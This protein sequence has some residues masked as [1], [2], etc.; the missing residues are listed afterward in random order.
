MSGGGSYGNGNG[1]KPRI[2]GPSGGVRGV[3]IPGGQ[4]PADFL[5]GL[6]K[7]GGD[8]DYSGVGE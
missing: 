2:Q 8:A 5:Q 6:V 4:L 3:A 7:V 1:S